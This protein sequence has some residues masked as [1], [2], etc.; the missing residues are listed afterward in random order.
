MKAKRRKSAEERRVY[1]GQKSREFSHMKR[2]PT[3]EEAEGPM[4]DP[5]YYFMRFLKQSRHRE[6]RDSEGNRFCRD[7]RKG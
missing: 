5:S 7:N 2:K 6:I 1:V 3:L 4:T